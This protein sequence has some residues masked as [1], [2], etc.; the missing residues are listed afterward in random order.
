[1]ASS[2]RPAGLDAMPAIVE[3]LLGRA[4]VKD[5]DGRMTMAE[6]RRA[7]LDELRGLG[8]MRTDIPRAPRSSASASTVA[9]RM[10]ERSFWRNP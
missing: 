5:R 2:R 8:A 1:M 10:S 9:G 6:M 3:A 4:L 7:L